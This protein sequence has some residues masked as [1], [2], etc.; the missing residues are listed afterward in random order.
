MQL[1]RVLSLWAV[2]LGAAITGDQAQ[3]A[4][5]AKE[6]SSLLN[7]FSKRQPAANPPT[8]QPVANNQPYAAAAQEPPL[9]GSD[10][11]EEVRSLAFMRCLWLCLCVGA[12]C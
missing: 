9:E 11:V 2:A 6:Q 8:L 5:A 1:F 12:S 3:V 10:D 4:S 7:F